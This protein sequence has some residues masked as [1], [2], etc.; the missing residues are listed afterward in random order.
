[1]LKRQI[2]PDEP[3]QKT[4]QIWDFVT[5]C[6]LDEPESNKSVQIVRGQTDTEKGVV[7]HMA[8][9]AQA[10]LDAS[11]GDEVNMNVPGRAERRLRVLSIAR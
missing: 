3:T 2:A 10:L 5:Y 6:Y 1:M 8:P 9:L 4:V 7:G 11:V